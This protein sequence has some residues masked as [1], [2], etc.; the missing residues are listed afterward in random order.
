LPQ[1]DFSDY[2]IRK[3]E[4]SFTFDTLCEMRKKIFE[5]ELIIGYDNLVVFDK[6]KNPDGIF[7]IAKV[8]VIKRHGTPAGKT[9]AHLF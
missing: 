5:I 6:W 4:V 1:F 7:D 9:V 8:I 2:E 3:G